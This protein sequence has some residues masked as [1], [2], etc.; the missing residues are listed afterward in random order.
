MFRFFGLLCLLSTPLSAQT[1]SGRVEIAI[2]DADELI[3]WQNN[4]TG[5]LRPESSGLQLQQGFIRTQYDINQNWSI[6]TI[7]NVHQDGN[8][9]IGFTQAFARYKPL[10]PS[11]IKFKSRIG[12]FYPGM[13]IEN[14]AHGWLSPYTFTQSAINSW[15]GEEL[16]TLGAELSIFSNGRARRSKWSW[17]ATGGLFK[18][19][20]PVGSLLTWRGFAMHDRQSL[21]IDRINFAPIPTIIDSDLINGPAW[22]EPFT[23]I[24]NRWGYYL[25]AQLRYFRRSEVRY[26]YYDNRADPSAQNN[27]NLYAWRTTFNSFSAQHNI[28]QQWRVMAQLLVGATDMGPSIVKADF[29]AWYLAAHYFQDNHSLTARYDKFIV[30]EN[31]NLPMDQN[32]SDGFGITIAW[33]YQINADWEIGTEFHYN[34]NTAANREQLGLPVEQ[35]QSQSRLVLAFNF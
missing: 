13:S 29:T 30:R 28:D 31:D 1:I 21:H 3:T 14:V 15:V 16:R 33:R 10:T 24:D 27:V 18:G 11:K 23:E 35:K 5:I 6:D 2:V 7:L 9:H 4:G 19:N 12:F 22:V 26:Y 8:E 20:D 32:D 34:N 25:G 17:E